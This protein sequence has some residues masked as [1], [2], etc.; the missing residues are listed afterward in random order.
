MSRVF[1]DLMGPETGMNYRW[2]QPPQIAYLVTTIDRHGNVNVTPGTLGTCVGVNSLPNPVES[3]YYFAFS[4]GHVDLLDLPAGRAR[5]AYYNLETVPECVISYPGSDLLEKIWVAALPLP[6]GINEMDVAGFTPL[7]SRKVRP[8]GIQ[9]CPINMEAAVKSSHEVGAHFKLYICQVVG[10]SVTAE[11][12][13][14]DET[15]MDHVGV[16]NIDPLFE[17]AIAELEDKPLRLYFGKMDMNRLYRT[18]DDIGSTHT[19][20]G[21]FEAWMEDE[22]KREKIS[23]EQMKEILALNRKWQ[24]NPDPEANREVKMKLTRLLKKIVWSRK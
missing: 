23:R 13:A 20:V 18:P 11:L 15:S 7:P 1:Y 21:T 22:V 9:E 24:A 10:V 17:V 6:K 19:W 12:V 14:Q 8:P 3:N 4:V 16:L 2:V 5:D